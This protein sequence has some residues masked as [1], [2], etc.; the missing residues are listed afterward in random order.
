MANW[1]D[2]QTKVTHPPAFAAFA[3]DIGPI[4]I[5]LDGSERDLIGASF[6]GVSFF[7]E[8]HELGG[9]R[10][11]VEHDFPLRK[12]SFVD[13]LGRKA[14][15]FK[16][17]GYV[18]GHTYMD[19]RD[20]LRDAL[21]D[22]KEEGPG[23]LVHPY[24]GEILCLC[25]TY[26]IKEKRDEGGYAT[27]SLEFKETPKDPPFSITITLGLGGLLGAI[28]GAIALV[29]LAVA[30]VAL[31][32]VLTLLAI[33]SLIRAVESF[34]DV[35]RALGD[36]FSGQEAARF[37]RRCDTMQIDISALVRNPGELIE[38]IDE[39]LS[40]S[41][42]VDKR[43]L[44]NGLL[45]AIDF[46]PGIAPVRHQ[47]IH[48][49]VVG[50][51]RRVLVLHAARAATGATFDSHEDA[52]TSRDRITDILDAQGETA[53]EEEYTALQSV[54]S[55][56]TQVV[57]GPTS[58]LPHVVAY[59]PVVSVPSLVLAYTLYGEVALE[60]DITARNRTPHPGFVGGGQTIEVLARG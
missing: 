38:R 48:G 17:E 14:R 58:A 27:F 32:V 25:A 49:A 31:A 28:L 15:T 29:I 45:D 30:M 22:S 19:T 57:P 3:V 41:A 54:R 24:F 33:A 16:L 42:D 9:G 56:L 7:V 59:T 36:L 55:A 12:E 39:A 11:L 2:N 18:I 26:S 8:S 37:R 1:R 21:E 10:R 46:D 60:G 43:A 34:L 4:T 23:I 13:D 53:S 20:K 47:R 5:T 52:V 51:I 40:D 44:M 6:R 50:A 35:F